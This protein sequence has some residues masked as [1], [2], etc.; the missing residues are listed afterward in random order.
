MK[1]LIFILAACSFLTI[2]LSSCRFTVGAGGK[3]IKGAHVVLVVS[4]TSSSFEADDLHITYKS[5]EQTIEIAKNQLVIDGNSYGT[6]NAGDVIDA[7]DVDNIKVNDK[8]RK[9]SH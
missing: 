5:K 3:K 7:T 8:P 4:R 9:I 6:L 1:K 2:S